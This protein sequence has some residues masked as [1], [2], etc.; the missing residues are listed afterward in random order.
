MA[1]ENRPLLTESAT[2]SAP[3]LMPPLYESVG[4]RGSYGEGGIVSQ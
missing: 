1:D 2:P 4:V 3:A